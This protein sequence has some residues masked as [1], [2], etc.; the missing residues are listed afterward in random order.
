MELP[1]IIIAYIDAYNRKDVAALVDCV[2]EDISF[3]NYSNSGP[4]L[5]LD[6][7]HAFAELAAQAVTLF[8]SRRQIVKT[9][10][11]AGDSVALEVD[12]T[13]TPAIDLGPMKAGVEVN[14]RGASFIAISK[15][16]LSR[17]LDL[18]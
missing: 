13:G 2:A 9:A 17:I 14:M 16:K 1:P 5:K 11:V 3:E 6:G 18:S 15:G 8:S 12:W 10:V 7:R 4:S